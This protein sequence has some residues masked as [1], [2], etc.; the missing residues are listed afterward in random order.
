MYQRNITIEAVQALDS[1]VN[2]NF[3]GLNV[4]ECLQTKV[5]DER[6]IGLKRKHNISK[7]SFFYF[8]FGYRF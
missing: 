3:N 8:A 6:H 7:F 5:F 4:L 1:S 2:G